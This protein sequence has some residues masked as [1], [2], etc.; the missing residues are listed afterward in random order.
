MKF[1]ECGREREREKT[2]HEKT[3]EED[4]CDNHFLEGCTLHNVDRLWACSTKIP[5]EFEGKK[6]QNLGPNAPQSEP[7]SS[8]TS[9]HAIKL[10]KAV[11]EKSSWHS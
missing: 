8:R 4:K 3:Y 2:K 9:M 10:R 7:Q 5:W 1:H 11:L 6:M